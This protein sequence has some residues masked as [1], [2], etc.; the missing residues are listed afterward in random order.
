MGGVNPMK[1]CPES[2]LFYS[3]SVFGTGIYSWDLQKCQCSH[4]FLNLFV[5]SLKYLL[6]TGLPSVQYSTRHCECLVN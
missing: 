3:V 2:T 5:N 4:E 1:M 6:Y